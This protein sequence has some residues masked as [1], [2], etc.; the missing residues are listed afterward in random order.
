MLLLLLFFSLVPQTVRVTV[1]LIVLT[2]KINQ[3]KETKRKKWMR[4][5]KGAKTQWRNKSRKEALNH[6]REINHF[7][8]LHF[9]T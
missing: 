2:W 1:T 5:G 6:E 9:P 7:N 4:V 8:G 3:R